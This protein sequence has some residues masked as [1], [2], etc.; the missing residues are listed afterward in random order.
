M[1]IASGGYHIDGGD[2]ILQ[3]GSE[4]IIRVGDGSAA[5]ASITGILSANLSG[6]S[7]LVKAD[8]GTLVLSGSNSYSGGTEIR[9]GVLAVSRDANLGNG[10]GAITLNGGTLAS[11]GSFATSRDVNLSQQGEIDVGGNT[12]LI[13]SGTISGNGVLNKSGAGTLILTGTNSYAD[14]RIDAGTLIGDSRSISGNLFNS[15]TVI[16][17]QTADAVYGGQITGRG[18]AIKRGSGALTL[19]GTSRHIWHIEDGAV[20]SSAERYFGNTQVDTSGTLRFE[21]IADATFAGV[22]SGSGA[23]TKTGS[24]VLNLTGNSGDFTGHTRIESGALSM[25]DQG[26][27]GGTLTIA[28]GA[29]LQ[30]TGHVG[31][32]LLQSGASIAPGNGIGTL[33]VTGDLTFSPGALYLVEVDANGAA[34]DRIA[35][36]GVANLAGSVLHVGAEGRFDISHQYTILTAGS[37]QGKFESVSSNFEFLDLALLYSSQDVK[38]IL[39]RKGVAFA[40]AAQTYNQR[41]AANALDGL[42]SDSLLHEYILTLPTGT[43]PAV[44][45]SLSGELHA[46]ISSGLVGYS[47]D[48]QKRSLSHMH[49][50]L[51]GTQAPTESSPVWGEFWGNWQNLES[52]GNAAQFEQRTKG[53]FVGANRSVGQGWQLGVG[54][55]YAKGNI[56]V[57]DRKSEADISNYSVALFGGNSF[58]AGLGALNL[59]MGAAY[60]WHDIDTRRDTSVFA[61]SQQLSSSY[62]AGTGQVFAELGYAMSLS[63]HASIQPFVGLAWTN[64]RTRG[65]AESGGSAALSGH[66]SDD[67]Q[68][69]S[70]LGVRTQSAI[71]FDQVE[72][73]V[74]AALGWQHAYNAV[75]PRKTL[76]FEG[77]QAFTVAGVP[78]ARDAAVVELGVDVALTPTITAGLTYNGQF[79]DG[80]QDHAGVLTVRWSY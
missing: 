16:F 13:L 7:T 12:E 27:L 45:D 22:L 72:G 53:L 76:S 35:V 32:T 30:G 4:S 8:F 71:V 80:S 79:G 2:I 18:T 61:T 78:M 77:S 38:L 10:A 58:E 54:L 50:G 66:R 23:F 63:E 26:Q 36:T 51:A 68:T 28:S 70:V 49:S 33:R 74:R 59:L 55:G 57:D 1:Q 40:G 47:S 75:I 5:S 9:G 64:L 20:V 3:G 15:G 69:T 14:T 73:Q 31:T 60:T 29:T 42:P 19:S 62:S 39:A 37:V 46:S 17:A 56:Y 41:A 6:A 52:D 48:L 67:K 21:Q 43:A 24:G 34:S 44:F 11:T 25:G 65:F